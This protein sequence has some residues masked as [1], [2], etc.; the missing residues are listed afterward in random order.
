MM[1]KLKA[2]M[3]TKAMKLMTDPKVMKVLSN[4][5][6][7]N[8]LLQAMMLKGRAEQA[9]NERAQMLARQLNLATQEEVDA[10]KSELDALR[11]RDQQ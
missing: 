1:N 5:K 8:V 7:T 10:L 3:M 11:S 9:W 4:P 6:V 2:T